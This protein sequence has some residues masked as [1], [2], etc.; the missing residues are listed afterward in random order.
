MESRLGIAG[1][2]GRK[3]EQQQ[4]AFLDRGLKEEDDFILVLFDANL[5]LPWSPYVGDIKAH[6]H[7][8]P[9]SLTSPIYMI[10]GTIFFIWKS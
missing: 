3:Q 9:I 10:G 8:Q 5:L 1:I 2:Q 4:G 6:C 7:L